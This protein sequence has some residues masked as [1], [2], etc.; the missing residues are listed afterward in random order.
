MH[1]SAKNACAL[2]GGDPA[3]SAGP[4]EGVGGRVPFN[5]ATAPLDDNLEKFGRCNATVASVAAIP[6]AP[7]RA[8]LVGETNG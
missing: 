2:Q 1:A 4:A 7:R 3:K 6:T 8:R 5:I